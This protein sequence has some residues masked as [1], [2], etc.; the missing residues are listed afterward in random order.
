MRRPRST[1]E[2]AAS[3]GR[4]YFPPLNNLSLGNEKLKDK[5][6]K[7]MA[8]LEV[9]KHGKKFIQLAW[10]TE[11]P[12]MQKLREIVFEIAV[13]V[14]A[15]SISIW[16]HSMSEHRHEQRQVRTFLLGL[17]SDLTRNVAQLQGLTKQYQAF[18]ANYRYLAALDVKAPPDFDK[19]AHRYDA[20]FGNAYF[21]PVNSRFEGFKSSGKLINI[22]DEELLNDVLT[23]HE[24]NHAAINR[25]EGG[26]L[27][28]H[29]RLLNYLD[30][31]LAHGDAPEQ[32]YH[33]L[34]SAN[35][36]RLLR[37]MATYPQLYERYQAA[38][39]LSNKIIR[40]IDELYAKGG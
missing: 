24:S 19:L 31:S 4:E 12:L 27:R 8:E 32:R 2:R 25:S 11:Y 3:G 29:A 10:S 26:W 15:V 14:F 40:R 23:L 9:A 33:A 30:A 22:E 18:D 37:D 21:V 16:F 39:D 1:C 17:K 35:G 36:K 6:G 20:I 28:K 7:Q 34:T 13:I 5:T 38:I